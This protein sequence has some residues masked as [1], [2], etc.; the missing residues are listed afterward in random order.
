MMADCHGRITGHRAVQ[1]GPIMN[2]L[3][4]VLPESAILTNVAGN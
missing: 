4:K 2:W 1:M 3:E